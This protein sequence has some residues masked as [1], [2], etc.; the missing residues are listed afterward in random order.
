MLSFF[1]IKSINASAEEIKNLMKSFLKLLS[2]YSYRIFN[3]LM[4]KLYNKLNLT[5]LCLS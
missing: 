4:N 2:I 5:L 1:F 3:L